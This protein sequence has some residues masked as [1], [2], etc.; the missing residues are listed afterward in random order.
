MSTIKVAATRLK[1]FY[2]ETFIECFDIQ[3]SSRH[4]LTE[5]KVKLSELW[6]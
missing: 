2:I 5:R 1:I 3:H 6:D 4:D